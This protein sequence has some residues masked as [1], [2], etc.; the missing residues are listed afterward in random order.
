MERKTT[1]QAISTTFG[2]AKKRA[3]SKQV[4]ETENVWKKAK[5]DFRFTTFAKQIASNH[6][7]ENIEMKILLPKAASQQQ[8]AK[9]LSKTLRIHQ[10]KSNLQTQKLKKKV[11]EMASSPEPSSYRKKILTS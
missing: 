3:K 4:S 2:E 8:I 1:G 9:M 10:M 11:G 5:G 7:R 6:F